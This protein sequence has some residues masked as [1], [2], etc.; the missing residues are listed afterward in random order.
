[1]GET[2]NSLSDKMRASGDAHLI[3]LADKFDAATAGFYS[4]PQ[5][6]TVKEFMGHWARARKAWCAH[7]GEALI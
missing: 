6:C 5:T 4:E 1:M 7:S 2:K 3:D